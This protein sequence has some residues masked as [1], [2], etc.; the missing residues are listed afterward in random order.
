MASGKLYLKL[1][2]RGILQKDMETHMLSHLVKE[3]R[4]PATYNPGFV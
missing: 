3:H 2:W 4:G 1:H